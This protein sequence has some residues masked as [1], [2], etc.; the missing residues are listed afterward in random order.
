MQ[1]EVPNHYEGVFSAT[2]KSGEIYYRSSL[3]FRRKHISLGSYETP[4]Q[5]HW[6]YLEGSR[7]IS[8]PGIGLMQYHKT[9]PL[10][11]EKWVCLINFRDNNIYFGTPIYIGQRLF[12]YYLSPSHIL[13]FDMDLSMNGNIPCTLA[14]AGLETLHGHSTRIFEGAITDTLRNVLKSI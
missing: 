2:K 10:P 7:L 6:A 8:E 11:F 1:P 9:S 12:Y 4:E 3:T 5:A 14:A 13:K